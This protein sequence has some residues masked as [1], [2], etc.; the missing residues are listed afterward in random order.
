MNEKMSN[1]TNMPKEE[2]DVKKLEKKLEKCEKE[3][4]EYLEGWKRAK[5]TALNEKQQQ[6]KQLLLEQEMALMR[7]VE[8]M[9][10]VLDSVRSALAMDATNDAQW[11]MGV[12]QI[13]TQYIQ[14]L[15]E[16]G[17]SLLDPI[18][19]AFDPHKH[20]SIGEEEVE[21]EEKVGKVIFVARIGAT[22]NQTLIRA[23]M[24]RVGIKK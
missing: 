12:E 19:E 21:D 16:L 6:A 13:Q 4:D 7:F 20:E 14:S 18:G 8:S 9:L 22:L 17:V 23:P 11:K 1:D 24:V 3:R 5:A 10:P 15:S 2:I